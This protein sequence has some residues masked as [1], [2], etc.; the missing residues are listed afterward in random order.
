LI[1]SP[2]PAITCGGRDTGCRS[3]SFFSSIQEQSAVGMWE[4]RVLC[5]ISKSRWKPFCGFHGD[6]W[7]AS[8]EP[9]PDLALLRRRDDFY[10]ERHRYRPTSCRSSRSPP[11]SLRFD[12]E[13][14][15]LLYARHGIPEF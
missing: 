8:D 2:N 6:V 12:R 9:Q 7:C 11:P 4:S 1:D 13:T 3:P 5:E 14:K 10:R 15:L